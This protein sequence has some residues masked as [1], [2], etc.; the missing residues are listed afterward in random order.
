MGDFCL[1]GMF[2]LG[3]S[4]VCLSWPQAVTDLSF[5]SPFSP[6]FSLFFSLLSSPSAAPGPEKDSRRKLPRKVFELDFQEDIDFPAHFRK[7][8]VPAEPL[9]PQ[10]PRIPR[11][12]AALAGGRAWIWEAPQPCPFPDKTVPISP[13][14]AGGGSHFSMELFD[15]VPR[16]P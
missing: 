3:M 1:E 15:P 12:W 11:I 13:W 14:K 6:I 5:P 4:W 16:H 2:Q 7:T 8:K 9:F 10:Q